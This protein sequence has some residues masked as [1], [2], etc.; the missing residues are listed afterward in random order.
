MNVTKESING[1]D[2]LVVLNKMCRLQGTWAL[3][4]YMLCNFQQR[5]KACETM[6]T[7]FIIAQKFLEPLKTATRNS[8]VGYVDGL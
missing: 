3:Q 1:L 5:S 8:P 2:D 4:K 7:C 6:I